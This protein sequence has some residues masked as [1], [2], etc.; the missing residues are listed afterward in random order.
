[1]NKDE[2]DERK[3]RW[4]LGGSVNLF[5]ISLLIVGI[6]SLIQPGFLAEKPASGYDIIAAIAIAITMLFL[7]AKAYAYNVYVPLLHSLI[8]AAIGVAFMSTP[9]GNVYTIAAALFLIRAIERR[10]NFYQR[11]MNWL[12]ERYTTKPMICGPV[13]KPVGPARRG[14]KEEKGG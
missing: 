12:W 4:I 5:F 9:A 7:S 3:I 11:I 2:P 10:V 1:M 8:A 13:A 14:N 6:Y